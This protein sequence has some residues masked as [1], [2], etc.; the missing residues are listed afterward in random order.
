MK[1][2]VENLGPLKQAELELGD[3]TIIC[4]NNNTGKTYATYALFGFLHHWSNMP[5]GTVT[6]QQISTL[7]RDGELR[8]DVSDSKLT[9]RILDK[10]CRWYS[11]ELPK[12]LASKSEH[13]RD[14]RFHVE[15]G[16][17][18]L[19]KVSDRDYEKMVR[20]GKNT[21]FLSMRKSANDT[22]LVVTLLADQ[23]TTDIPSDRFIK[24]LISDSLVE[25]LFDGIFPDPFIASAER[26]GAAIF[27]KE[28]NF[29]RNRL[30]EEMARSGGNVDPVRLLLKSYQDYALP[31]KVNADFIRNLESISKEDS[32]L[33]TDHPDF[34][35]DF[36][37]IIGGEYLAGSNDTLYFKPSGGRLKLTMDESSSAVRSLLDT[38][39]YLRHVAK[40]GDLLMMDEPEL[41][42]HPENQR[43]IARL[44][45]RLVNS[46]IRVFITTHSDYIVKELNTLIM[47]NLVRPH[48]KRIAEDE[49]Y[50]PDELLSP[51]Q[52]KVYIAKA[53]LVQLKQNSKRSRHPTLVKADVSPDFGISAPSFDESINRM[54]EIQ[55]AIVWGDMGE[56]L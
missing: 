54:N 41:N 50:R 47:L 44:F 19:P 18:E 45:A 12:V 8:I 51:E 55:D 9:G 22:E 2:R 29:A 15:L 37:D 38:G 30:L 21:N 27:R 4:G 52:V 5:G 46:G 3:L 16:Y 42:L 17:D 10:A 33:L 13:L 26:T 56:D 7:L 28:L 43:R 11:Q 31:V 40:K 49:G 6:S 36:T 32:A 53:D 48:L 1:V 24:K 34:L 20:Q 14:A 25:I 39:F 35:D 23:N